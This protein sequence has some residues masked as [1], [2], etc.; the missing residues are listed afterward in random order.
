M[1]YLGCGTKNG[2]LIKEINNKDGSPDGS[3]RGWY[4]NGQLKFE[5]DYKN[6]L[7]KRFY[8][9]GQLKSQANL[10]SGLDP[11]CHEGTPRDGLQRTWFEDGQLQYELIY[12]DNKLI[13]K[14]EW[15]EEGN[16]ITDE[17]Y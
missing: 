16:L 8:E 11:S 9:N 1:D 10:N 5:S 6:Q 15:D 17:T 3:Y 12:K 7:Y 4:E 13:S 14:K 2:Q